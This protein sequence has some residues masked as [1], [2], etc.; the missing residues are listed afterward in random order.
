MSNIAQ[1]E[2][3]LKKLMEVVVQQG[4]SDLHISVARHPTL[5]V[6]GKLSAIDNESV[7]TKKDAETFAQ[8]LTN[9]NQQKI[10]EEEYQV[11]F[12]YEIKDKVRFRINIY[13]EMGNISIAMRLISSKIRTIEELNLPQTLHKMLKHTQGL[14]L[15]VGPTGSG[16][17][18]T[19]ASMIDEINHNR[20]EHIITIEDPIEYVYEQDR[21]IV[22]Q[23][24]VYHDVKSFKDGLRAAFR[25]D[26][27]VLM[28]GEMR[29][30][31]TIETTVTAAETGHLVMATLHTNDSSQTIDRIIDIFPATQQQ[32]IRSQL[33]NVLIGVISQ[34]LIPQ[35]GGGRIPAVELL[36][37]NDAVGNLIRE[38]QIHQIVNTLD[39]SV[40]EGMVSI[41][42][43]LAELV[44]QEQITLENAEAYATDKQTLHLLLR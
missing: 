36:L 38:G 20:T 34:R 2:Q 30:L 39:T 16:K 17:S 14:I 13:H 12:T 24:E 35:V 33:A 27:N 44:K 43:S 37:N 10:L 11:D 23:R 15:V 5:R 42:R 8:A 32:Q 9:E 31:E 1:A 6:D 25:E 40:E 18:T 21:S 3:R 22:D 26:V 28:V 41:N 19:L 4:A 7:I 29:D